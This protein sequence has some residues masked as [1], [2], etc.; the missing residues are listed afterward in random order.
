MQTALIPYKPHLPVAPAKW[1]RIEDRRYSVADPWTGE[2]SHTDHQ[3][4]LLEFTVKSYTPQGVWLNVFF[5]AR[6]VK[7][8]ATKRFA[9]PTIAEALE[10]FVARKRRQARI[11]QA[12][13]DAARYVEQLAI[14][15]FS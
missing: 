5:S 11:Y 8:G 1:Y 12:R 10:S 14:K 13:A 9:C 7:T 15:R 3:V 4:E 6:W 2:H